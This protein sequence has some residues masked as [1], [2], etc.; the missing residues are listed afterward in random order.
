MIKELVQQFVVGKDPFGIEA[1]WS[2]MYDHTFWANLAG[3]RRRWA[4]EP[5]QI[6]SA[7]TWI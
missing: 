7:G 3:G 2:D 4:T 5:Q 1:I 6:P